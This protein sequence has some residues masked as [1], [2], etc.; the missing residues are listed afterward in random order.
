MTQYP[1]R[2]FSFWIF[3]AGFM[4]SV[5]AVVPVNLVGVLYGI[6]IALI[7]F[8]FAFFVSDCNQV[9]STRS[10]KY[11]AFALLITF[12]SYVASDFYNNTE[13]R[14]LIRGW[15]RIIVLLT[16]TCGMMFIVRRPGGLLG[17]MLGFA[18]GGCAFLLYQGV[19]F[20]EWKFGWSGPAVIIVLA[21]AC[22]FPV[23]I[24]SLLV[25]SLGI[26]NIALDYRS[27]GGFC[28]I[29]AL[30]MLFARYR[31][32]LSR[33]GRHIFTV[34]LLS[35]GILAL[36][37]V[38]FYVYDE[39]VEKSVRAKGSNSERLAS[40]ETAVYAIK[41]S[42]LL[43]YGSWAKDP[44][45]AALFIE[46]RALYRD[47]TPD[48]SLALASTLEQE[49]IPAHSQ[50]LQAWIE[51]GVLATAF[52]I[53]LFG[54]IAR[55]L[56]LQWWLMP[57]FQYT[58]LVVFWLISVLWAILLSPF[59]AD[60]RFTLALGI[61]LIVLVEERYQNFKRF[62]LLSKSRIIK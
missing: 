14:D 43:G 35:F 26:L 57:P 44:Q 51:G 15:A 20:N 10:I 29:V 53:V 52:F 58:P 40:V 22:W 36:S 37:V 27:M 7:P 17:I 48:R 11:L 28:M 39:N 5:F 59:A 62:T 16:N 41:M 18:L 6:E 34:C 49:L 2:K 19:P 30:F 12:L 32:L 21:L 1:E 9:L 45:I 42:P 25:F 55:V 13:T 3:L 46:L 60:K 50:V 24:G 56:Y 54:I 47:E 4:C 23:I 38:Y 8:A 61:A 31:K 33:Q